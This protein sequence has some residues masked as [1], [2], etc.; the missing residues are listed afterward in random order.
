MEQIKKKLAELGIQYTQHNHPQV[1]TCDDATLHCA[2]ISG[3]R[4]KNLFLRN[5]KGK[6][7][8]LVII[9]A[10]KRANLKAIAEQVGEHKLSFASEN[11]LKKYLNVTPGS[12]SPFGLIFDI[13]KN[14]EVVI[15]QSLLDAADQQFHPNDNTETLAVSTQ[16]FRLFLDWTQNKITT[17]PF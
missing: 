17:M 9:E 13:E 6:K 1:H 10:D 7:H 11:R 14:V 4:S 16:D 15:S 12:V 3:I 5:Q 2:D 8:F